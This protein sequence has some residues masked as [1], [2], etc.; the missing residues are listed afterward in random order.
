MINSTDA[1][2]GRESFKTDWAI[3]LSE[4]KQSRLS[5]K[6]AVIETGYN[7]RAQWSLAIV[8]DIIQHRLYIHFGEYIQPQLGLVTT[9]DAQGI[10]D[11]LNTY[12]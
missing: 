12:S 6:W 7:S 11:N 2:S 10:L 4:N 5:H 3:R 8:L 9:G 1:D